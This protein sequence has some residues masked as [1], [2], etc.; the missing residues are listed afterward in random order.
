MRERNIYIYIRKR[1]WESEEERKG[2]GDHLPG[3]VID[4][5]RKAT[6]HTYGYTNIADLLSNLL[7]VPAKGT[8]RLPS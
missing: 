7:L 4:Y 3:G 5:T 6:A 8:P 2:R 1:R